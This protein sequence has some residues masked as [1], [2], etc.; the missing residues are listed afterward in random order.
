MCPNVCTHTLRFFFSIHFSPYRLRS[1]WACLCVY[2][3]SYLFHYF[4]A[5]NHHFVIF[6]CKSSNRVAS[7]SI[8]VSSSFIF[9]LLY[10]RRC[11]CW[12]RRLQF[13]IVKLDSYDRRR[14]KCSWSCRKLTAAQNEF[15]QIFWIETNHMRNANV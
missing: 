13:S 1:M 2:F 8:F 14:K 15:E 4:S 6:V 12:R 11:R 3:Q 7:F 10:C 5:H 9:F